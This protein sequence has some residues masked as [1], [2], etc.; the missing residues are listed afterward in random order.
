MLGKLNED[1]SCANS[2]FF[3][4]TLYANAEISSILRE[5]FILHW[6]SVRPAPKVTIDFGDG[7]K[8]ERTLTG[9]SIHYVLTPAG[10]VVDALPGLYGPKAFL[11]QV[12]RGHELAK[13][14]MKLPATEREGAL[15]A[16]HQAQLDRLASEWQA[17]LVRTGLSSAL[18]ANL[19][20]VAAAP[21]Q[22]PAANAAA[23]IARPK[24]IVEARLVRAA[25]PL[26]ADP[27]QLD[28]DEVWQRIAALYAEDARLDQSSRDLIRSQNPTAAQAVPLAETKLRV[29]NPLVRMVRTL[30]ESIAVDTVKNEYRLHREIHR[31]LAD[32]QPTA[33]DVE[34]LN[35]RVYAELF[36]TPSSDP[37][38]GLAPADVYTALPNAGVN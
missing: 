31:W 34:T 24:A 26:A 5:H 36:L 23:A 10:D 13:R 14:L 4:T 9:N 27:M 1:Y 32:P 11:Q 18:A 29:E 8:L 33:A 16:H 38:L 20:Q 7:R 3:R 28:D 35:E 22:P 19:P 37:W 6:K 12:R 30:E 21:A 15:S 25:L 17:D 2:R